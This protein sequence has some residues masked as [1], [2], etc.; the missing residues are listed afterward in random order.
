MN[1]ARGNYLQRLLRASLVVVMAIIFAGL[2]STILALPP[3]AAGLSAQ[4]GAALN[5]SGIPNPITATLLDFRSYDTLL[6]MAVLLLAVVAIRAVRRG[7]LAPMRPDDEILTFLGR[8]LV[9]V[10]IVIA[11]Y[12]L[13]AGFKAAGGAFQA[14]AILSA[15]GVLLILAGRRLPFLDDGLWRRAALTV[16]LAM[17][18]IVG[19]A[20][21]LAGASFLDYPRRNASAIVL[22]LEIGVAVSVALALLEAFAGVLHRGNAGSASQASNESQR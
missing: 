13:M 2:G 11:G 8:I 16:G 12:L 20:T 17:F 15:A 1:D 10:M 6:E 19:V 9:P 7:A 5:E 21:M 3:S 14:G 4:V 22:V 18:I